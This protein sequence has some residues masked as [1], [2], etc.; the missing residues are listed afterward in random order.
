MTTHPSSVTEQVQRIE[1]KE[2]QRLREDNSEWVKGSE[3]TVLLNSPFSLRRQTH[4]ERARANKTW[5]LLTGLNPS[6]NR[7]ASIHRGKHGQGATKKKSQKLK[8]RAPAHRR[9]ENGNN[10]HKICCDLHIVYICRYC[11]VIYW[12][13]KSNFV[14]DSIFKW[15]KIPFHNNWFCSLQM[16]ESPQQCAIIDK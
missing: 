10:Q 2:I 4:R 14:Y 3:A 1:S 16:C 12:Q 9:E 11:L 13:L 15:D 7:K 6:L 8:T 5:G